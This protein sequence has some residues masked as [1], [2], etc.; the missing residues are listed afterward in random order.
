M[1]NLPLTRRLLEEGLGSQRWRGY[2][3]SVFHRNRPFTLFGGNVPHA[4]ASVCWYSA[5]KPVVAAGVLRLLEDQF[6]LWEKPMSAT[7]PELQ[8]SPLGS[9][10]LL[11]ILIHRTGVRFI[12][13]DLAKTEEEILRVLAQTQPADCQLQ[14]G[15]AA[16]DPRGGWWLLGQW[17]RRHSRR[18]WSDYLHEAILKPSGAGNMFFTQTNRGAEVPMEEWKS[19]RWE[20]A[21]A[22]AELGNLCGSS[23]DLARFYRTLLAGGIDPETGHQLLQPSTMDKFLHRQREGQRD[24]TFFHT[25]D[26]GL[27]VIRD[28][29]RYGATT[30]PYGFGSTSSDRTFGHG[31]SRSSIG[32]ADPAAELVVA[33]CLLGQVAEPRHQSR[34]REVLDSLRSELA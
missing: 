33:L 3:L 11:P 18:P 7:F 2:T 25:V 4:Q 9:L 10:S 31:G 16:Y 22:M 12:D 8:G 17:I 28:S 29:N 19:N 5:G 27:G 24:Q 32:F 6:S 34:M 14:P 1:P 23:M 26:F 21:P 20:R 15:Q 13:L 30:V